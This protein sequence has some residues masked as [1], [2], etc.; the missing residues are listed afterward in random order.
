MADTR[1]L[2]SYGD[3]SAREDVVMN[4][5]E[6]LTAKE[7]YFLTR[8]GRTKAIDTVH[9][10]LTDTLATAA[11][12]AVGE[13]ESYTALERSTPSRLTNVVENIAIPFKVSRT[14]QEID[15]YHGQDELKRQ[16]QKALAEFANAAE[17]DLV[18][19]TLVS[20][21]SGTAPKMSGIIE[22]IS[23]SSNTTAHTSGTAWSASI[24]D[25][26]MRDNWDNSNGDI[27][28]ELHM[29]SFLRSKTDDFTQKS[30]VV[31][32]NAAGQTT[33]VRTVSTYQTAFGTLQINTHRYLQQSAD[34][35]G[36]VLAVNP[37]KL[38]LAFL[39]M[40]YIDTELAR[41]G[42]FDFYAVAGKMTLEV[43][44]QD[45]NWFASG[46]DKD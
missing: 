28:T 27:A 29:G 16:T 7:N 36:R 39:K 20:G 43:Q 12:Q 34:A 30:N 9:H 24:L 5:V 1:T 38:A 44:N 21:V 8:L 17:F 45:S 22:A 26:L 18:R 46:F 14:Q 3:V 13:G 33:I 10:Y 15:H 11:S 25:G 4:A 19:S 31:V 40:P 42:D 2:M 6:I 37:S 32:N 23:K 35:T 41:D